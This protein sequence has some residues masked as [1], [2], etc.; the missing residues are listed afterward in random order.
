MRSDYTLIPCSELRAEASTHVLGDDADLAFRDFEDLCELVPHACCTLRRCVD[1]NLFRLPV[2]NKSV[3]LE[4]RMRLHLREVLALDDGIGFAI[5][6]F[7]IA[8]LLLLGAMHIAYLLNTLGAAS[9]ACR[10]SGVRW[11]RKD[12]RSV[13]GACLLPIHN[14]RH[15]IIGHLHECSGICRNLRS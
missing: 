5:S 3:C 6:R 15:L 7:N 14:K 12:F 4:R 8:D 11:P 1:G 9:P 10:S 2:D 13:F